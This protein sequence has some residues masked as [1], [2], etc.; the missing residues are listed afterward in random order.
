MI[1][2]NSDNLK[3]NHWGILYYYDDDLDNLLIAENKLI[4]NSEKYSKTLIEEF[5]TKVENDAELQA[6]TK[7]HEEGSLQAQYYG[8]YY[9]DTEKIN[10]QILQNYRKASL[11][12]IFSIL[13]GQLKLI[14]KLVEDEF[15][16][17]VKIK[18]ITGGD[19]INKYW[20]YLTKVFELNPANAQNEFNL[21]RQHKYIRNKIAHSNS[22]IDANKLRFVEQTSGLSIRKFGYDNILEIS[23]DEYVTGIVG[24]IKTFFNKLIKD[25]DKRYGEIKNVG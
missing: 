18:H 9:G 1:N 10:N 19:Y 4:E 13:E 15:D 2:F 11:L 16:F 22:E 23:S 6:E 17:S 12:S 7:T 14:S 3:I 25:V 5:R 20:L 24:L 21:I 8:H